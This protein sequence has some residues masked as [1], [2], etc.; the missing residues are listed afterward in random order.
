MLIH[1][2]NKSIYQKYI[3]DKG[4]RLER[5]CNVFW[6]SQASVILSDG[7]VIGTCLR[8]SFYNIRRIPIT[9]PPPVSRIR[10]MAYGNKIEEYELEKAQEAGILLA[11]GVPFELVVGH[12]IIKGKLDGI[13]NHEQRIKCMEYKTSGGYSFKKQIFGSETKAGFPRWSNLMQV[14]LYLDGFRE[15][16]EYM[17]T[18]AVLIYIDRETCQTTE[19]VITLK[20]DHPVIDG[21]MI[22]KLTLSS[23][24]KRYETLYKYLSSNTL[25][26]M[27]YRPFI[28]MVE[29]ADMYRKEKISKIAYNSWQKIGYGCDL[30][31]SFCEWNRQCKR[32][33]C[34]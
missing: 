28:N 22:T 31:C 17:F 33:I 16:K 15:H 23:I 4:S 14:M 25:P 18:E 1:D 7:T 19:F 6:P 5:D 21:E 26:P 11:K 2:I 24:Y 30:D 9:D 34:L 10:K 12:I 8:Q 13:G 27:D 32:D 20:D 3:T 29:A